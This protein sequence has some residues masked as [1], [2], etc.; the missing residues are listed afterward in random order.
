MCRLVEN[1]FLQYRSCRIG[2]QEL[3]TKV[4]FQDSGSQP[5]ITFYFARGIIMTVNHTFNIAMWKAIFGSL[6]GGIPL[7]VLSSFSTFVKAFCYLIFH[8]LTDG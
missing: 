8:G 4:N 3:L 6:D 5:P 7:L 1:L 2:T